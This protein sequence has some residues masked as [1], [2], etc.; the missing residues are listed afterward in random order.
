MINGT[1]HILVT[2]ANGLIGAAL[3]QHL[4]KTLGCDVVRCARKPMGEGWIEYDATRPV[5]FDFA[6]DVIVHP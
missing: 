3:C 1:K 4:E 6:V 5:E 2:G